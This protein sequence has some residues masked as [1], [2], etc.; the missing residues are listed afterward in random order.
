MDAR[1]IVWWI[2]EFCAYYHIKTHVLLCPRRCNGG[3]IEEVGEIS[4]QTH[5]KTIFPA[6]Q[7]T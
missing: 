4:Q 3:E 5:S 2:G 1:E 6:L 7:T